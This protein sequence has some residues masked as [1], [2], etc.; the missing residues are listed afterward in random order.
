MAYLG[1][2]CA[3]EKVRFAH[4]CCRYWLH[5]RQ[6]VHHFRTWLLQQLGNNISVTF[7]PRFYHK[8]RL[9]S[10]LNIIFSKNRTFLLPINCF[11]CKIIFAKRNRTFFTNFCHHLT[12][13]KDN[14]CKKKQDLFNDD[15]LLTILIEHRSKRAVFVLPTPKVEAY[16]DTNKYAKYVAMQWK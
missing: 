16:I 4:S 12:A 9:S 5:F 2:S 11:L 14:S 1:M 13:V 10:L 3:Q 7:G 8:R 6:L 15:Q